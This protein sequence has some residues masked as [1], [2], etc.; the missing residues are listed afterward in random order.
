MA[1]AVRMDSSTT[2]MTT[3]LKTPI[4]SPKLAVTSEAMLLGRQHTSI[5]VNSSTAYPV[6]HCVILTPSNC[7]DSLHEANA[8]LLLESAFVSEETIAS[9]V[10]ELG[11]ENLRELPE[12]HLECD[13]PGGILVLLRWGGK[14]INKNVK[15]G[16][17]AHS[18]ADKFAPRTSLI[19]AW[20]KWLNGE[21][22]MGAS[23]M[24]LAAAADYT[25]HRWRPKC[26]LSL[27][28][29]LS[30]VSS[31]AVDIMGTP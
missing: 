23:C 11:L 31:V 4:S 10:K 29:A 13:W 19:V 17:K 20:V 30:G 24:Q 27:L 9:M 22:T 3:T 16:L 1:A 6:P 12:L 25:K 14:K 8:G 2:F 15:C 21:S 26:A 5:N 7:V 18:C 28:R